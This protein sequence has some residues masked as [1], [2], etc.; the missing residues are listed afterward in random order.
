M[1]IYFSLS[2]KIIKLN[3]AKVTTH[4]S[5]HRSCTLK[6]QPFVFIIL[7]FLFF[8]SSCSSNECVEGDC[9]N[10]RGS[11]IFVDGSRYE[12]D[13][14]DGSRRGQGTH[15]FPDDRK[16]EG[17]FKNGKAGGQGTMTYPNGMKYV[18]DWKNGKQNGQGTVTYPSGKTTY[19]RVQGWHTEWPGYSLLS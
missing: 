9:Q 3:I 15:I 11:N 12:G 18:G 19:R 4:L 6:N 2:G 5:T 7:L 13:W 16:Y 1:M 8:I 10:G 17:A 14:K